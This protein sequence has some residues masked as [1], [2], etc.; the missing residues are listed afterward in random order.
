LK[1]QDPIGED[2]V[3]VVRLNEL[4]QPADQLTRVTLGHGPGVYEQDASVWAERRRPF[5]RD[6]REVPDVVRHQYSALARCG[7]QLLV[8]IESGCPPQVR[9]LDTHNVVAQSP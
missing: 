9:F 1:E 2:V 8:I 7:L 3:W 4:R 6:R 5:T